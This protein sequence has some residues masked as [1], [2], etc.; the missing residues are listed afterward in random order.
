VP[1]RLEPAA[2]PSATDAVGLPARVRTLSL[3]LAAYNHDPPVLA[4]VRAVVSRLDGPV[5]LGVVR[6]ELSP[7]RNTWLSHLERTLP[8]I[9]LISL[10][11]ADP[12]DWPDAVL[13]PSAD[14]PDQRVDLLLPGSGALV[15]AGRWTDLPELLTVEFVARADLLRARSALTTLSVLLRELPA[16][17]TAGRRLRYEL[18]EMQAGAH[19][20]AELDALATLHAGILD[21]SR[22]QLRIADRLLGRSGTAAIE[23]LGLPGTASPAELIQAATEQMKP[24]R[25]LAENA[26]GRRQ[27][28]ACS[29]IVHTCERLL[30]EAMRPDPG[31]EGD[32]ALDRRP[33]T[34]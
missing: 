17:D 11:P 26:T 20:L 25:L 33:G 22:S 16:T 3:N 23:R 28:Q 30:A 13:Q 18:E 34:R 15:R 19:E 2:Q 27:R 6:T 10:P 21:L 14:H 4:R 5:R 1:D 8:E 32:D 29:V 24:W 9:Q 7:A 12:D 31:S